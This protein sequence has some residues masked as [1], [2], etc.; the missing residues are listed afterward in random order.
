MKKIATR[1]F[2][3]FVAFALLFTGL[4]E[5]SASAEYIQ[6]NAGMN[7]TLV[8]THSGWTY[9][10]NMSSSTWGTLN[11]YNTAS[12]V[13]TSSGKTVTAGTPVYCLQ[14]TAKS[15]GTATTVSTT[16]EAFLN[17]EYPSLVQEQRTGAQLALVYGHPNFNYGM[18]SN[19]GYTVSRSD[20]QALQVATQMILWEYLNGYRKYASGSSMAAAKAGLKQDNTSLRYWT[21][22]NKWKGNLQTAYLSIL[23]G[24][25]QHKVK[26]S[27]DNTTVQIPYDAK[28]ITI[29][30]NNKV[31]SGGW[32]WYAMVLRGDAIVGG[33]V[34]CDFSGGRNFSAQLTN[35]G[36]ITITFNGE[37][38]V[39]TTTTPFEG[40]ITVGLQKF[41]PDG[42]DNN[43]ANDAKQLSLA[44]ANPGSSGQQITAIGAPSPGSLWAHLYLEMGE[45]TNGLGSVRK[46]DAETGEP[47]ARAKY[48]L[49]T[50]EACTQKAK[51]TDGTDA[52]I[53]TNN[54]TNN[55][56]TI[57]MEP[58]IYYVQETESP[59]GYLLDTTVYTIEVKK[60]MT[61][62]I[63]VEDIPVGYGYIKKV[64]AGD[65]TKILTGAEYNIYAEYTEGVE[66]SDSSSGS[67]PDE[68]DDEARD[69]PDYKGTTYAYDAET[70]ERA[71]LKTTD[72]GSNTITL[73][74]GTY[75]VK[76]VKAPEGYELDSEVHELT[77]E[78]GQT[79]ELVLKDTPSGAGV[80]IQ[81]TSS[82]DSTQYVAGA[83]YGLYTDG[84]CT[85]LAK[86][87]YGKDAFFTTT[88]TG[89]NTI[90]LAKAG[91]YYVQ[92]I[93]A[94]DGYTLSKTVYTVVTKTGETATVEVSDPPKS[95]I[96]LKKSSD[97]TNLVN[98]NNCYSLENAV[99]DVF[100]DEAC[101]KKIGTLTTKADGTTNTLSVDA[102]TYYAKEVT[103]PK[104][105][106]LCDEIHKV[107]VAAGQSGIF[108]C[109]ETPLHDPFSLSL[110]KYGSDSGTIGLEGAVF[111]VSYY[112][113]TDGTDTGTPDKVWY[114]KT[115]ANGRVYTSSEDCLV[116]DSTYKSDALYID[117]YLKSVIYPLGTYKIVEVE[118]PTL[119]KLSGSMKFAS[120]IAGSASVTEGMKFVIGEADG[121]V[122]VLYGDTRISAENLALSVTDNPDGGYGEL[123]KTNSSDSSVI[124]AGATYGVYT[125]EAC[126]TFAKSMDTNV[127]AKL[128]TTDTGSN[129]IRLK[130]GTYY[131]KEIS[132]PSGYT[133]STEVYKAIIEDGKTTEIKVQD[134]PQG[135]VKLTKSSA[136]NALVEG[137][138]NYSLK[139][140]VYNVYSD[141]SCTKQVGTLTT[142]A[143]GTTNTIE[144]LDAGTYYAK[145]VTASQGYA[146][147]K[148]VHK[149]TITAGQIGTFTCEETP[150]NNP[151][152]LALTK[153]DKDSK[154][155]LEGA[156]FK[157]SF[158][159]NSSDTPTRNWYFKTDSDGKL[160]VNNE[161][162]LV[163]DDTF[164]SDTLYKSGSNV[165]FPLG[166]YNIVEVQ[167]PAMYQ[168][169]G[170]MKFTD[171]SIEGSASVTDG[172]QLV[173]RPGADENACV[174]YDTELT[175]NRLTAANL[176]IAATN[177]IYRGSV[178]VIKYD[179]D[180]RTP[181]AGVSF[182]LVGDDGSE[183]TGTS[184]ENGNVLF[185]ELIPQHYVLTETKTVDGH[186]L[187]KD[188]VDI[189]IPVQ[190]T[191]AEAKNQNADTSKA[192]WNE[193]LGTYSFYDVTYEVTNEA[194]F[195]LPMTGGNNI[196]L[197][198]GLAAALALIG[199]S[200]YFV[201][202]RRM[203]RE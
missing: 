73:Y 31:I 197:Y 168:L 76:E 102:G 151:F 3:L 177:E 95:K 106:T 109:E 4:I 116:N 21:A 88:T 120:N 87:K 181:L 126:T 172:L 194:T 171:S 161:K 164:A 80:N 74:P 138:D 11:I 157:V 134:A 192:I 28:T 105:Y 198:A 93:K 108:T 14:F 195:V 39:A 158:F 32:H 196:P 7:F 150:L 58:G 43:N 82:T 193:N 77:I 167:A 160:V 123:I 2:A 141:E 20:E 100:S 112:D 1:I 130:A 166:T 186:S 128:T 147:C 139:G 72:T 154:N 140:A 22:V 159:A 83:T 33:E 19:S 199:A 202:R 78:I 142:K 48:Q 114:F 135:G 110:T 71:V 13:K 107:T 117:P 191:E 66:P 183:Y 185:D 10:N 6:L 26:P 133:L 127:D 56:T 5:V 143:D 37:N 124:V 64:D 163:N 174:Y 169:S 52:L 165:V 92:E 57:E 79:T 63:D 46:K 24:I 61:S 182:K 69:D 27:F 173:I 94:P 98:D 34:K 184:D 200:A 146:L 38:I 45:T 75:F 50:D 42:T 59:E 119:Y 18:A 179:S 118:A 149:V 189:T 152:A 17:K 175:S 203:L 65:E 180:G 113:N 90:E 9:Q 60:N 30:D 25:Q 155:P 62:I 81:K 40:V 111:K 41:L 170:T 12:A 156:I 129:K 54:D 53:V 23:T 99:Y 91:T 136:N 36:A 86:D 15:P 8:K 115:D 51:A 201:I 47:V 44:I 49:Y 132:A 84:A 153:V 16:W 96:S 68:G 35:G 70:G 101:T 104:G 148:E 145:E 162:Y 176:S 121:K 144:N 190:M 29:P 67:T 131:V 178:K 55:P 89:S 97:D 103:A 187:L 122:Q 188:N 85:T 125:D 137:N